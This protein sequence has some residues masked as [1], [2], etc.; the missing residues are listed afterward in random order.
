MPSCYWD[1]AAE[2]APPW[3]FVAVFFVTTIV[4]IT[5]GVCSC[6]FQPRSLM[7]IQV[8]DIQTIKWS[9]KPNISCRTTYRT[10]EIPGL[11]ALWQIYLLAQAKHLGLEEIFVKRSPT[12][13]LHNN[14]KVSN[15]QRRAFLGNLQLFFSHKV[16]AHKFMLKYLISSKGYTTQ[17]LNS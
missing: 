3:P 15:Y 2:Q 9:H 12:F 7:H 13:W 5:L 6:L 16:F 17:A 14:T 1:N 4:L 8:Q 10:R 11:W